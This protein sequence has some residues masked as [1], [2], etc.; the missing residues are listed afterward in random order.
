MILIRKNLIK[1]NLMLDILEDLRSYIYY[2]FVEIIVI[3]IDSKEHV[4]FIRLYQDLTEIQVDSKYPDYKII[5]H[6]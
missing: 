3:K 4:W 2:I 6:R 1:I 5:T